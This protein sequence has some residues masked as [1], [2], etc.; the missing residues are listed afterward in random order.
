MNAEIEKE[1]PKKN[2]KKG[3]TRKQAVDG[4]KLLMSNE[5]Y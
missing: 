5:R 4:M 1:N 3:A 2:P